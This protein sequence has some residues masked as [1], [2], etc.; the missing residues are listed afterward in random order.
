MSRVSFSSLMVM[1]SYS[2]SPHACRA[3][4]RLTKRSQLKGAVRLTHLISERALIIRQQVPGQRAPRRPLHLGSDP[5]ELL[6][7]VQ[8]GQALLQGH[9]E[10]TAAVSDPGTT[11][12]ALSC[13]AHPDKELCTALFTTLISSIRPAETGEAV[14]DEG[15]ADLRMWLTEPLTVSQQVLDAGQV[16]LLDVW[17]SQRRLGRHG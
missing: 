9:A 5:A 2:V 15:A 11:R 8:Q 13:D 14:N 6:L 17:R 4:R 10:T 7:H 1:T 12:K 3:E 16:L